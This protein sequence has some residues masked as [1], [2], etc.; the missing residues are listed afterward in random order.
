MTKVIMARRKSFL[1]KC[2][3]GVGRVIGLA[4]V[5]TFK[6][7]WW[8][9][10][11]I[12]SGI[13]AGFSRTAS[14][15]SSARAEQKIRS[16][17]PKT[18]ATYALPAVASTVKGDFTTF[19]NRL[20][21]ESLIVAIAGR[22][23]SGKSVLG[24]RLMENVH[25]KTKRPCFVLGVKQGM[26]PAWIQSIERLEDVKNGGVVLVDEGAVSF[27]SRNSMAKENRDLAG[28]LAIARHKDLTLLFITQNTGMIDKNVLNLCDVV[29]LKE[30]SL[31]QEKMERSVM[32]DLYQTANKAISQVDSSQRKAHCYVFDAEYEGLLAVPLPSFW[33]SKVSKNQA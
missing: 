18:P 14:A 16:E 1:A 22:R 15:V 11:G 26:L 23:G 3:I 31:L 30:G 10:R 17:Q 9:V 8:V 19:E 33:S 24:F 4:V 12:G 27:G 7:V 21:K 13:S 32:K 20:L 25:D 6:G 28:L 29:V 2:C 5:Y